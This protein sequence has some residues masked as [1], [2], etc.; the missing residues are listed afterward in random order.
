MKDPAKEAAAIAE[1]IGFEYLA[2]IGP[3]MQGAILADLVATWLAGHMVPARVDDPAAGELREKILA[4]WLEIV[5]RLVPIN[6]RMIR[7]RYGK[8]I[9]NG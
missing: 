2:G 4:D 1:T 6:E 9:L 8:G 7:E 5:R 3:D